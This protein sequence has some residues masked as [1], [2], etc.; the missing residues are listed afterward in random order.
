MTLDYNDISRL[1]I[2]LSF[3]T[4]KINYYIDNNYNYY[5]YN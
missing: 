2:M 1:G 4:L 3:K 5:N